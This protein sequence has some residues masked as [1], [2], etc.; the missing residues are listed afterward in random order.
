[1]IG[2]PRRGTATPVHE[3]LARL[4]L[5]IAIVRGMRAVGLDLPVIGMVVG[6]RETCDQQAGH[7]QR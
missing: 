1:V 7:Q 6:M 4:A 2:K 5:E 3:V